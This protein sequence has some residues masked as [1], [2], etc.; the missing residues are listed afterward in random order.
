[1]TKQKSYSVEAL[2]EAKLA[3]KSSKGT[4]FDKMR[5]SIIIPTIDKD[6]KVVC[7]DFYVLDGDEPIYADEYSSEAVIKFE[8]SYI[9]FIESEG[10]F[11][12]DFENDENHEK[13]ML[14]F[15]PTV[16]GRSGCNN[17]TN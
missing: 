3:I 4:L 11:D 5:N 13:A 2:E 15:T 8:E 6:G 1:M 16:N 9:Q 10:E 14:I 7:F 17:V 12:V